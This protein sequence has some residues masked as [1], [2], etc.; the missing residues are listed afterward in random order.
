MKDEDGAVTYYV[1]G[2]YELSEGV[3]T[4]RGGFQTRP[5]V[6]SQRIAMRVGPLPTGPAKA[7]DGRSA[8]VSRRLTHTTAYSSRPRQ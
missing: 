1:G 3:R 5:Y 4:S 8:A 2:L 6:A 7:R